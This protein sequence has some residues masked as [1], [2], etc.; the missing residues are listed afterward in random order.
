MNYVA[1]EKHDFNIFGFKPDR[2]DVY[3]IL[4][5]SCMGW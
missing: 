4:D 1:D 3:K 5:F 2:T